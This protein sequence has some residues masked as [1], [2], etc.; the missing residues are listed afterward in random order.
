[1]KTT[2]SPRSRSSAA[3]PPSVEPAVV[4]E[5]GDRL[6]VRRS[7][8][9]APRAV[10]DARLARIPGYV[11]SVG[12][13]VIVSFGATESYVIAVLHAAAPET[14]VLPDGARAELDGG[15]LELRD[16]EGRLLVRY[17]AGVAEIAAPEGDLRLCAPQG[18]VVVEAG[19]DV[20]IEGARDVVHRA[21]RRLDLAAGAS[22]AA[23]QVRIEPGSASVR[24]AKIDVQA[25]SSRL[26]TGVATILAR[27]IATTAEEMAIHVSRHELTATRLVEKTRDAFRD[28]ADLAQSRVGRMRT[29]VKDVCSVDARRNV[30][31]SREDTTIDG[32]KILLG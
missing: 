31:I 4:E 5:V 29:L 13:R 15:R 2:R 32:K 22:D 19:L 26:V 25:R 28:V 8:D 12:D 11:P 23:P 20:S 21:G 6:R 30:M 1:M 18:R 14:W 16:A 7:G 24:A 10:V 17:Q 9:G 27:T 3:A